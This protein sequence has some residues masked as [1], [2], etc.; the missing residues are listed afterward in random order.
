MLYFYIIFQTLIDIVSFN[1]LLLSF[2]FYLFIFLIYLLSKQ[3]KINNNKSRFILLFR[4]LVLLLI[5]PLFDNKI[6]KDESLLFRKQN[7]GVMID[8]SLSVDKILDNNSINIT[9]HLN[10]IQDWANNKN[11]N[12]FWYNLDSII[13]KDDLLFNNETTSFDHIKNLSLNKEVDQLLL[14][15]D[16]I[17]NSGFVFNDS[18]N[19]IT[20]LL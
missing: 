20:K 10:Q 5:I 7:I 9:T 4:F 19:K 11:V 13:N 12:L 15:S 18:Y 6:F 2:Y 1:N 8:N 3:I 16:G 14:I 17:I